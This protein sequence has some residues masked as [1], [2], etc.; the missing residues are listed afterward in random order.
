MRLFLIALQTILVSLFYIGSSVA[1]GSFTGLHFGGGPTSAAAA[2]ML[3]AQAL[4]LGILFVQLLPFVLVLIATFFCALLA[5]Y[6]FLRWMR[7]AG[8]VINIAAACHSLFADIS[9]GIK[10]PLIVYFLLNSVLFFAMPKRP[11]LRMSRKV[12]ARAHLALPLC[13]VIP[14]ILAILSAGTSLAAGAVIT[15]LLILYGIPFELNRRATLGIS[16]PG[17]GKKVIL[18]VAVS[19]AVTI[20]GCLAVPIL[21]IPVGISLMLLLFFLEML[22]LYPEQYPQRT[23]LVWLVRLLGRLPE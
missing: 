20:I 16:L 17:D 4:S 14:L 19:A 12:I 13:I 21:A 22:F 23:S 18:P 9:I 3:L 10:G 15:L 1:A 8:F 2:V 11:N 5:G 7:W 6:R